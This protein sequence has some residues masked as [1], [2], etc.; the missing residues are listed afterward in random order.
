MKNRIRVERAEGRMT[1]QQLA[2]AVG[3]SRQT[4]NAVE[5]G[6]FVPSTLLALKIARTFRKPVEAIFALEE[7]E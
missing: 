4:V 1:Q 5:T 2:D 6:K 7:G 3:V